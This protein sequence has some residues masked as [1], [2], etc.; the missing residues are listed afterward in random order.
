MQSNGGLTD[1][2]GFRGVNALLSGPAGGVV[3]MIEAG[4]DGGR[5][6]IIGLD[7]GGTS[8][9]LSLYAGDLPRRYLAR[10]TAYACRLR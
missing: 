2:A 8:T 6:R 3:G 5:D 9:D 4:G 7:M 1:A 10:S